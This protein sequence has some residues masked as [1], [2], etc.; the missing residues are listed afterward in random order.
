MN[1]K[2]LKFIKEELIGY[3]E[4]ITQDTNLLE[5]GLDSIK[6]MR[7]VA[8]IENEFNISLS[9]NYINPYEMYSIK[10]IEE[11]IELSKNRD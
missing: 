4:H 8:F 9:T 2:L 7:L 1:N 3:E 10:K 6:M 5:L 11:I